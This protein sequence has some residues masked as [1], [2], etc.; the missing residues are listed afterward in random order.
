MTRNKPVV[1]IDGPAAS[2][3]STTARMVARRLGYLWVDTGAM[4][5]ALALKALRE[6]IRPDDRERLKETVDRTDVYLEERD[7]G[8]RV[9]L[10]GE[11]VTEAIRSPEVTRAVSW[12]CTF[13]FVRQAMMRL[14]REMACGG[15]VVM[16][17]RDIGTVV[18][19]DAEV[20]VFL[21]ADIK[22]RARRRWKE[23]GER[24]VN[25]S[26][27]E[28]ERELAERDRK[29]AEREHAP[30]RR[31]PDAIVVD[32]TDLSIDE[33]VDRIVQMIKAYIDRKT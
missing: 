1:A 13:P 29:D 16:E 32:T 5:R 4:Y 11:D 20:K 17:G 3:K 26:L 28:V 24:G 25:V 12:V 6:G 19:P 10:D 18:V 30:L 31:A 27:E 7:G 22:E 14:Q 9:F 23:L 2:G 33:Q 21:D 15:G 8:L